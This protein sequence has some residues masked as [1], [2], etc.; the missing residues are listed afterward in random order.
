MRE[1][2]TALDDWDTFSTELEKRFQD[3]NRRKRMMDEFF[4]M[5]HS[6]ESLRDYN[7]IVS[8]QCTAK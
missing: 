8:P 2:E 3:W 7:D 4:S 1:E 6:S 5:K